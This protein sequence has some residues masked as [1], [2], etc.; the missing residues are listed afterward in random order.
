VRRIA[1]EAGLPNH[2]RKDSTGICFIGERPFREFLARYLPPQPGEIR[3][4]GSDRV[5][6]ATRA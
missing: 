3:V 2:A 5:S 6:A 1:E 4:L